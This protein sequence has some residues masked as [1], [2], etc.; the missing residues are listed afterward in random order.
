MCAADWNTDYALHIEQ[1]EKERFG[2]IENFMT[3]TF[4]ALRKHSP[5]TMEGSK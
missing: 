2:L 5:E 4:N 1:R 3:I